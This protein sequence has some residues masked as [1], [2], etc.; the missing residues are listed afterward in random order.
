MD[1]SNMSIEDM[2]AAAR[3]EKS[4]EAAPAPAGK[5]SAPAAETPAAVATPEAKPGKPAG[6]DTSG[7]TVE[8]ILAAARGEET[9]RTAPES[10]R[11]T[12]GKRK[13]FDPPE[14]TVEQ[15]LAQARAQQAAKLGIGPEV[16][17]AEAPGET[18]AEET[19]PA[20]QP[21]ETPAEAAAPTDDGGIPTDV[22]GM[23]A[24]CRRVDGP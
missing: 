3:A 6:M 11:S 14:M 7:M 24:Y 19:A 12:P 21:A 2:L 18:S 15:M 1:R 13:S 22:E 17:G 8:E 16:E 9:T 10:K 23:L 5:Q 4:G 20:E